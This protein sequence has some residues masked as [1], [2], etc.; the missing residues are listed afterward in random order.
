MK[1]LLG[2]AIGFAGAVLFAPASGHETR[3]RLVK[4]ARG[5]QC[6]P[7]KKLEQRAEAAEQ[8][9]GDMGAEIG[10]RAAESAVEAVKT[11]VSGQ[12]KSA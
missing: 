6:G 9:A 8:K 4:K 3:Q 1:F 7:E 12:N 2:F 5:W 10:R 11:R